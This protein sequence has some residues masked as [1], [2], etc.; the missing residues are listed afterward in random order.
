M[1]D[2]CKPPSEAAERERV[3]LTRI[4]NCYWKRSAELSAS[5]FGYD[6]K[7]WCRDR[8]RL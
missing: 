4:D 1:F 6:W 7:G 2:L 8:S 5:A 3:L